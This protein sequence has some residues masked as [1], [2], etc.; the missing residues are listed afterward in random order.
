MVGAKHDP[1][2]KVY[3]IPGEVT[4][5]EIEVWNSLGNSGHGQY[6]NLVHADDTNFPRKE[7]M[8]K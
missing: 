8:D 6:V 4:R 1:I 7:W 5:F 3:N 2:V